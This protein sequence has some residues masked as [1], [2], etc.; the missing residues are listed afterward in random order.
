VDGNLGRGRSATSCFAIKLPF[1]RRNAANKSG[2]GRQYTH[3][4]QASLSIKR[5]V[6]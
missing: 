2:N 6:M 4:A 3:R 5:L 1:G